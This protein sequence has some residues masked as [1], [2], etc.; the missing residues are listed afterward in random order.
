MTHAI[1]IEPVRKIVILECPVFS[2]ARL[3]PTYRRAVLHPRGGGAFPND[4]RQKRGILA[5][6]SCG[7]RLDALCDGMDQAA[8]A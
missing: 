8:R 3:T 5:H 4:L 1:N 2:S 6:I 7:I